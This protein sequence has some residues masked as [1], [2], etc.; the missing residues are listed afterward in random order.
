MSVLT[1]THV[2]R[3][4]QLDVRQPWFP[5]VSQCNPSFGL[6]KSISWDHFDALYDWTNRITQCT[7]R[8]CI[9]FHLEITVFQLSILATQHSGYSTQLSGIIVWTYELSTVYGWVPGQNHTKVH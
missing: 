2:C 8:A 3:A 4:T 7:S 1:G 6:I 9:I 5:I